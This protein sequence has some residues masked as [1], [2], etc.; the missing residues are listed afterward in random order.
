M[1][2]VAAAI[3]GARQIGFT[4]ISITLSLI[5]AFTPL[6]FM[7]GVIGRIFREF[8][9]TLA[10]AIAV[11]AIVSL[12]VTPMIC[13]RFPASHGRE[14]WLD[15]LVEGA[16]ARV[17]ASY[18]RSLDVALNRPY[19]ILA[20]FLATIGLTV[21]MFWTS[22]KGAMPQDETGLLFGW[23][24]GSANTSF[25]AMAALQAKAAA[26]VSADPAV[27]SVASF[28]GGGANNNGRLM[29]ALK[30]GRSSQDLMKRLRPKLQQTPGLVVYLWPVQDI[31][32]GG[33]EGKSG[34][35]FTLWGSDAQTVADWANKAL[36]RLKRVP[37]IVDA[38]SDHDNP[39][40]QAK[41]VVDRASAARL[42]VSIAAI[43]ATLSNALSQRQI[44]TLYRERN[45]YQVVLD[46]GAERARATPLTSKGCTSPAR[47]ACRSR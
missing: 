14:T 15:R 11:S 27:A 1:R 42:G 8:A 3:A 21:G 25:T 46:V 39:G 38:A 20:L 37:Q 5:A 28:V 45:Q 44:S 16:L 30:P 22:P 6:L 19:A 2:P 7:G 41:V 4:V 10:F 23:T 13:G 47:T 33:R 9:L 43:D 35:Q 24:E 32:V 29:I 40:L 17:A 31:Q 18:A 12:T 26:I 34:N 36:E